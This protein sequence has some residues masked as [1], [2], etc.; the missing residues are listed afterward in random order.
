VQE[1]VKLRVTHTAELGSQKISGL[2]QYSGQKRVPRA[3]IQAHCT[4]SERN[5]GESPAEGYEDEE[6]TG[7]SLL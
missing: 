4:R 2:G 7:A 1:R 5:S 3:L 6:G